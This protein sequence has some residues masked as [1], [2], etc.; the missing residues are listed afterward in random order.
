[1]RGI[2]LVLLALV[3][4]LSCAKE[5]P[6]LVNPPPPYQSIRIRLLN[7][8]NTDDMLS[9]GY[10]NSPYS[11]SVGYLG[12]T[13]AIMPPPYDSINVQLFQNGTLSYST[14]RK[15]RLI[16]ETRYLFIAGKSLKEDTKVDTI[17]VLS[18]TYGLP[19]KLGNSYFKFV[20]LVRD[21][22]LRVSLVDG[23]PNGTP[24]VSNIP[25]FS[26]PLLKT[27]PYGNY[28]VS[29]LL[30]INNTTTLYNIY[31]L[32][33][34]EDNEFTIFFAEKRDGSYGLFLYNDYDTTASTL[35][36]LTP[37][38]VRVSYLRTV[39]F[40]SQAIS[41]KKLPNENIAEDI[42]SY[43]CTKY[44]P[45]SACESNLL[46]TIEITSSDGNSNQVGYSFEVN[47][48]YTLLVFD[49]VQNKQ[50]II[51]VP[52]VNIK[53]ATTGKAVVRVV[54]AL[55]TAFA[56]TLSLGAR[57]VQ[58]GVKSGE[59]LATNLKSNKISNPA[60]I[61]PGYLP[62]TLFSSTESSFLLKTTFA[63]VLPDKS[64]L[65]IIY[66]NVNNDIGI[67]ILPDEL[68]STQVSE[69][70][71]GCFIQFLN[72]YPESPSSTISFSSFVENVV[73][74]YKESFAT[75]L[76]Q[77]VN[78]IT[79][80][81]SAY[82]LSLDTARMGMFIFSGNASTKDLFDISSPSMGNELNSYRRR[83]FNAA[84]DVEKIGIY[85]DSL[86]QKVVVS[87]LIYGNSSPIEK[88]FLERKFALVFFDNVSGK[89][90]SQYTDI[91][92]SFGKN[93]TL[94]F[95]GNKTKGYSLIVVQEY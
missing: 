92:L 27:I 55:D 75:V 42:G 58:Q 34:L 61:S 2:N 6:R 30:H 60:V 11:G 93:Y 21:S 79:I 78:Q 22:S 35:I 69:L 64:Y 23:C 32:K 71:K 53:E 81:G 91:F 7:A 5:D 29:V 16:R 36:E 4:L 76:P 52:E 3:I 26:Y 45:L 54:N 59:V 10:D 56:I 44:L 66:K 24:L 74:N 9:W 68:E 80:N 83:F 95:S 89:V 72:A 84:S 46:D 50:K 47:K 49:S 20:N 73:L 25:Y 67:V 28:T 15:I 65:V 85:Y 33:F 37:V 14:S 13:N 57:N 41:I 51:L 70:G 82:P 88:V 86:K 62:M 19:K 12:L 77:D 40:S 48:R 39:N 17:M 18:T 43:A 1:M 38:S 31:S 87:E 8:V 94:V 90:I 63:T